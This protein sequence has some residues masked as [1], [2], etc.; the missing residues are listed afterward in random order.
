MFD[1][2][3]AKVEILVRE[4]EVIKE[5]KLADALPRYTILLDASPAAE[6]IQAEHIRPDTVIAACGIPLGLSNEA[7]SI[8]R[9]RLVHDP[10]QIGVATMLAMAVK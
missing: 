2:D 4:Y 10:L 5:E 8:V 9:E 3:R 7:Y 1:I 6:I